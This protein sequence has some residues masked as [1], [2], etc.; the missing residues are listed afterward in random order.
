MSK[1]V[2]DLNQAVE[3][4]NKYKMAL[5]TKASGYVRGN[6]NDRDA[7]RPQTTPAQIHFVIDNKKYYTILGFFIGA[8]FA[9][10]L[11]LVFSF[12]SIS[13]VQKTYKN[14]IQ[15]SKVIIKLKEKLNDLETTFV[16]V[17][18]RKS[19]QIKELT[20]HVGSLKHTV[21]QSQQEISQLSIENN[22][23]RVMIND[24]NSTNSQL[25]EKL[26]GLNTELEKIK[27]E[28]NL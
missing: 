25:M 15:I 21:E 5:H 28:Q 16:S 13:G 12:H 26:I 14:S 17:D 8:I 24:L 2:N 27:R 11:S 10:V 9:V 22:V 19:D 1:T 3:G 7:S 23:L 20:S 18:S 6:N 4:K